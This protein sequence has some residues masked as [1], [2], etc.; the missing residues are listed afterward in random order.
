[1]LLVANLINW[2]KMMQE[3]LKNDWNP[4]TWVLIWEFSARPIQWFP[5]WQGLDGFQKSLRTC[6]LDESSLSIWR[7]N[8]CSIDIP[9]SC[10]IISYPQ[11]D[12]AWGFCN[13]CSIDIPLSC[14]IISYPQRDPAWG[15]CNQCSINI[16]LSCSIISYPQ[17]DPAWGFCNQCSINIPLSCS[18]ISSPQRPCMRVL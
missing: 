3:N 18:I 5:V 16:P 1:M 15:F 11:R 2:Y 13:Q 10:S 14:S 8:Q 7:V 17:R 6:A 4:G 12:P 9:L